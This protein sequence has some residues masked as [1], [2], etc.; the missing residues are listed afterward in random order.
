MQYRK[1]IDGLRALAVIPVILFHAGFQFFS[2]GFVGVDVF[3]V[4]SG[5]LV[6]SIILSEMQAGNFSLTSFYERRARRI[7]PVLFFVLFVCIPLAWVLFLPSDLYK[8]SKSL[9]AVSTLSS[10]L[11]FWRWS[12]YFDTAS[13]LKPLL[14]T[15]SLAVEEQFYLLFPIFLIYVS[16]ARKQCYISML[17]VLALLSFLLAQYFSLDRPFFTF[18]LLPTR[19]W[20]LFIGALLAIAKL[21][22]KIEYFGKSALECL[23]IIGFLGICISVFYFSKSTPTPSFFTLIPT[24]SAALL[25]Y[26]ANNTNLVGKLLSSRPM[27]SMGLISYSAYL[28]HQP[29]LAFSKYSYSE[30]VDY[31]YLLV[32][33]LTF[34][35]SFLSWKYIEVP[36]RD[37]NK[38]SRRFIFNSSLIASF[39]FISIGCLGIVTNGFSQRFTYENKELAELD[40]FERGRY[41]NRRFLE[42]RDKAFSVDERKKVL[43]IG[44]SYAEDLTNVV[45]ESKLI[46]NIQI[47]THYISRSCGNLSQ[48]FDLNKYIPME[49][50]SVCIRNGWYGQKSIQPQLINADEIWLAS[51][52]PYWT[53]EKL[54]ESIN[55]LQSKYKKKVFVFG[56]KDFGKIIPKELI[57][58][59]FNERMNLKH[60]ALTDKKII[61]NYMREK[62]SSDNYIDLMRLYCDENYKCTLFN[63]RGELLSYDGGHLTKS[64]A[65]FL[66]SK[67]ETQLIK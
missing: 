67:L 32:L 43:L 39:F 1:E 6:T 14:H 20:E 31:I 15:W 60:S 51:D 9:V 17:L 19:A 8:F 2:G 10:N 54:N 33:V 13:E 25:I 5:Y 58:I 22:S 23:S 44:D 12:G 42:L 64:G 47:S 36:F 66:G 49:D 4:I 18:Y 50:I 65:A 45:F 46:N 30:R 3:F 37:K 52:W 38:F 57:R 62:I 41:T 63:K 53:A 48:R 11:L 29:L 35:L 7:L 21:R 55:N 28:W 26:S 40:T 34:F 61:N 56:V 16:R 27:V 59:P 24:F